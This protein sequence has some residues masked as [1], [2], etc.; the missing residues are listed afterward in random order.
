VEES[1]FDRQHLIPEVTAT[2]ILSHVLLAEK[3]PGEIQLLGVGIELDDF[4][5][6]FSWLSYLQSFPCNKVKL[7]RSFLTSMFELHP[8]PALIR[9]VP[10]LGPPSWHQR[11]AL[12]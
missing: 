9:P 12:T 2:A 7:D 6:G 5:T 10:G 1:Q 3:L 4:S 11:K 8:T